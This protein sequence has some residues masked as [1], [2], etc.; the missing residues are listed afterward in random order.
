MHCTNVMLLPPPLLPPPLHIYGRAH[1]VTGDRGTARGIGY[2]NEITDNTICMRS[3]TPR[4]NPCTVPSAVKPGSRRDG[5]AHASSPLYRFTSP[6][7]VVVLHPLPALTRQRSDVIAGAEATTERWEIR[8]NGSHIGGVD[9][10]NGGN[11][12]SNVLLY[13][14]HSN[15]SKQSRYK[16][17]SR[18][19]C[20]ENNI[21]MSSKD[22]QYT[23]HREFFLARSDRFRVISL[24][25]S[26]NNAKMTACIKKTRRMP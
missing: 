20:D 3:E 23:K 5:W 8:R 25:G 18:H 7:D 9:L 19:V 14:K 10:P 2:G 22:G 16:C 6:S 13:D 21:Y 4:P 12:V 26:K 17:S 24:Y 11:R 1:D 15:T